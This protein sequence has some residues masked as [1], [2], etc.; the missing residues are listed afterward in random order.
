ML[1]S[2]PGQISCETFLGGETSVVILF[3]KLTF[4]FHEENT[5]VLV[6]RQNFSFTVYLGK[7]EFSPFLVAQVL[8]PVVHWAVKCLT[9]G[10]SKLITIKKATHSKKTTGCLGL[11]V[12]M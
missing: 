7:S 6:T 12:V 10:P 2:W 3:S 1:G 11:R 8:F 4:L 5:D 9:A